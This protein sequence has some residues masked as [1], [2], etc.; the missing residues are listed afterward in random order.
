MNY[1]K[2]LQVD[3]KLKEQKI[4]DLEDMIYELRKYVLS[5]KFNSGCELNGYV[6][7]RDILLR[8]EEN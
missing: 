8:T 7:I 3:I 6:N 4:K 2:S 1:I 5:D